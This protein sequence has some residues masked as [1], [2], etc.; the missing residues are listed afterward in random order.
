MK[1]TLNDSV[2]NWDIDFLTDHILNAHH[3]YVRQ[4]IPV[5]FEYTQ[6]VARV[7]GEKHPEVI[8]IAEKFLDL[9][10]ELNRHICKEEEILFPYIKHLA[11]ANSYGMKIEPSPF[12]TVE[13]PIKMMEQEHDI[14]GE[15][16]EEIKILS[17]N[18]SPPSDACTTYKLSYLK[19]KE[20][21]DDLH[22]HVHLENNILF[23]KAIELEKKLS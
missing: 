4:A 8:V 5:I 23:P 19:L 22:K 18:Y 20:F 12:G 11:I 21:E 14:V 2:L 15:I 3:K 9:T 13:S 16:M 10:D 1:Q 6:K 7:H 17:D